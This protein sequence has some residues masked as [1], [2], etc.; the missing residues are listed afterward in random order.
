MRVLEARRLRLLEALALILRPVS[1]LC[2][3]GGTTQSQVQGMS[4]LTDLCKEGVYLTIHVFSVLALDQKLSSEVLKDIVQ[5]SD[6]TSEYLEFM[7]I[8][9]GFI[10]THSIRIADSLSHLLLSRAAP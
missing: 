4:V 5:L 9:Y 1:R 7:R 10:A 3:G 6:P 8:M 2:G